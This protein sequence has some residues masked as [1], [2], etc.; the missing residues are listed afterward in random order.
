MSC[1]RETPVGTPRCMPA[2][3]SLLALVVRLSP[4][5]FACRPRLFA[6]RPRRSPLAVR[7]SQFSPRWSPLAV[8]P[9]QFFPR[10]SMSLQQSRVS[11]SLYITHLL[12]QLTRAATTP[13]WVCCKG[14]MVGKLTTGNFNALTRS[15]PFPTVHTHGHVS[16]SI[17]PAH[18]TLGSASSR[19]PIPAADP[20]QISSPSKHPFPYRP[21]AR[22][23]LTVH[24]PRPSDAR[25]RLLTA[26]HP[27]RRSTPNKLYIIVTF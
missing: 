6:C 10:P 1:S 13:L 9:S 22:S 21:H 14:L 5:L 12:S 18:P 27:C 4:S 17:S 24:K 16:P 7:P 11:S 2:R 15:T 25:L 19:L 23:R 20:R 3:S 8:R 26:T